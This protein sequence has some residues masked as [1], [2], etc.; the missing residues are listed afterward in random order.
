MISMCRDY[1]VAK[2]LDDKTLA[3]QG[4]KPDGSH[5]EVKYSFDGI[6]NHL[7][8]QTNIFNLSVKSIVEGVMEGFNGTVFAYG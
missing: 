4:I 7:T 6:F 8:T 3:M 1:S 2:F 5:G